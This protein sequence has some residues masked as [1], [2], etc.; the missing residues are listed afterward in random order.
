M[1]LDHAQRMVLSELLDAYPA[2]VERTSLQTQYAELG[3]VPLTLARLEADGLASHDD[4]RFSA[5][6]AAARFEEL[7]L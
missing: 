6:R 2:T 1:D 3:D 4:E 7:W 5:T